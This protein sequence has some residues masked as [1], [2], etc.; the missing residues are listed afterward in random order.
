MGAAL[1]GT[2]L[3]KTMLQHLKISTKIIGTVASVSLLSLAL[4]GF[5]ATQ[6]AGVDASYSHMIDVESGAVVQL[7]RAGR[8][9]SDVGYTTYKVFTYDGNSPEARSAAGARAE[10]IEKTKSLLH[11]GPLAFPAQD[12][13]FRSLDNILTQVDSASARAVARGLVNDEAGAR[14]YLSQMDAATLEFA[15]QYQVLRDELIAYT[16]D[17]SAR[18]T[19]DTWATIATLLSGTVIAM[20]LGIG[21]ALLVSSKGITGPL[22]RLGRRMSDLAAGNLEI[23]IDGQNRRDEVGSMAKAVQVFKDAA[24]QN[25]LLEREAAGAQAARTADRERQ[26]AIDQAKAEDLK[27]FVHQVERGFEALSAGDLTVRMHGS[28]APEF[29]PIRAQFNASVAQ[30]EQA[31][32]SVG[33]AVGTMRTGLG[34]ITIAATDLSQRTEQQAASLEQTVAALA[35]VSRGINDTADE[36]EKARAVASTAQVN[37]EKGGKVVAEA[38]RAMAEIEQSSAKISRIIG[39]IDEIAF[40]T[41]LLALNAGVEAARAGEA[42]RGFAVVAQEV[43][44]LAQRSAEAAKEIKDLISTSSVQVGQGVERVTATGQSLDDIVNRVGEVSAVISR[45][46]RSAAEQAVSLKEVSTAADNMDRVTQ[47]NAA[48]VEE[49]TAAAQSLS[50]ETEE[51]AGMMDRFR[52][53]RDTVVQLKHPR[54]TPARAAAKAPRLRA[55][56][57]G[58]PAGESRGGDD[59]V[60]F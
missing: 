38:V 5:A 22:G 1:V 33:A 55:V 45:I 36:A 35:E 9:V 47:Q 44:G 31:I 56:G 52:T 8:N 37:A 54:P 57:G 59:W 51:L 30:L 25:R 23:E 49:T 15:N 10:T 14:P 53:G 58:A 26:S 17:K 27:A 20:L 32:G 7:V 21:G 46:A 3:R 60:D 6:I 4:S 40:Q 13:K 39:V 43:R 2:R 11:A 34:E 29:E 48:M 50:G 16:A 19:A 28:V 42:G 12:A 41:N 24:I 18:L